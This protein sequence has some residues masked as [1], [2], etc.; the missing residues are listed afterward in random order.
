M[1]W[2]LSDLCSLNLPVFQSGAAAPAVFGPSHVH[3][4]VTRK[5]T[6]RCSNLW[7]LVPASNE[8]TLGHTAL[9]VLPDCPNSVLAS[10]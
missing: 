10:R 4:I 5:A 3:P 9:K 2:L 6:L 8:F 7:H 1:N